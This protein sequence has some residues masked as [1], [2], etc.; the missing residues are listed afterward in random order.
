MNIAAIVTEWRKNSHADVILSRICDPAAWGH[1]QPFEMN[2]V[3]MYVEHFPENDFARDKA[4]AHKIAMHKD[5]TS[6]IAD[7]GRQVAVD[8][9]LVIGEQI[10]A[11]LPPAPIFGR[12]GRI[13]SQ[14]WPGRA[15]FHRQAFQL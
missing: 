15:C 12:S 6:A 14:A 1:K 13:V 2:L 7:G 9:V 8:G 5:I 4:K 11:A 3:S 10:A